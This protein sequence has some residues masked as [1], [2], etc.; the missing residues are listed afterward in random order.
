[1]VNTANYDLDVPVYLFFG[2][3][4]MLGF[5]CLT[6]SMYHGSPL[7]LAVLGPLTFNRYNTSFYRVAYI[8]VCELLTLVLCLEP[9]CLNQ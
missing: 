2:F 9:L 8:V 5:V 3:L 6:G 1:M 7:L 4:E